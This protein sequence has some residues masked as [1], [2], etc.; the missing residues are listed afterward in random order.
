[1]TVNAGDNNGYEVNPSNAFVL[2]GLFAQDVNSGTSN[3][4]SCTNSS[5]DKQL[6]Y[7]YAISVPG[8]TITGIVVRLDALANSTSGPPKIC[9][10]LSWDGGTTWTTPKTTAT[11]K[12]GNATYLLGTSIDTW[13]HAWTTTQLS[14]ANF[15]V[16][17]IDVAKNT[18]TTFS[19]D[20]AAVQVFYR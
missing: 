8:G 5:K 11:L 18:S 2:D 17:V 3:N 6:F 1:V 10:Q 9:V 7:N 13:G 16:R 14:D 19:L 20:W 15:R 4:A 12:T